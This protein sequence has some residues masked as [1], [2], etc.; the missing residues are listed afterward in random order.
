MDLGVVAAVHVRQ[1][2]AAMRFR[3]EPQTAVVCVDVVEGEPRAECVVVL[4]HVPIGLVLVPGRFGR[5]V[6]A[7][8]D[9]MAPALDAGWRDLEQTRGN[10]MRV[11]PENGLANL[12]YVAFWKEQLAELGH[13]RRAVGPREIEDAVEITGR[14]H[15]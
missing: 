14:R 1:Y 2:L 4:G 3:D 13:I 10:A 12:W 8:E 7:L 9:Q 6:G 11:A 5:T 15:G